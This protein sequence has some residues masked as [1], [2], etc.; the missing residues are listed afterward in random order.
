MEDGRVAACTAESDGR[1]VG[2]S[3]VGRACDER[4]VFV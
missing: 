3:E 4:D 2:Y 1:V